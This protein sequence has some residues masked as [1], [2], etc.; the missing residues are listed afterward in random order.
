MTPRGETDLRMATTLSEVRTLCGTS[1]WKLMPPFSFFLKVMR[2][3]SCSCREKDAQTDTRV[4]LALKVVE[5]TTYP[6]EPLKLEETRM[7][8]EPS[9]TNPAPSRTTHS[10]SPVDQ[11]PGSH[12]LTLGLTW[13]NRMPNPSSS[14]SIR[15]LWVAGLATSSTISRML[16]VRAAEMTWEKEG[17]GGDMVRAGRGTETGNTS[18][19]RRSTA[20]VPQLR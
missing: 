3:G 5:L 17:E 6:Y 11:S 15:I 14:R 18:E 20:Q 7:I 12:P 8:A 19:D 2:G 4:F 10:I 16:Q 1:A 9:A 13:F